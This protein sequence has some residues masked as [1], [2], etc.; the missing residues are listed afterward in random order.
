M[1]DDYA[2]GLPIPAEDA[3]RHAAYL[4]V[5]F[6]ATYAA[7]SAALAHVP[8]EALA[9]VRTVLDIGAGPGTASLAA[10][11][12]APAVTHV[13]HVDRS[14]PLLDTGSRLLTEVSGDR[15]VALTQVVAD[16]ASRQTWPAADLVMAAYALAELPTPARS[17]LVSSAWQATTSVLVLVEPGTPAGF[18]RIVEARAALIASGATVVAPCPHGGPCPLTRVARDD[19]RDWCHFAVRVPRSRRH[20]QA[21]AASRGYEDE[22]L[23]YLV[24][25]RAHDA[26]QTQA[27]VLRH[28]II[29]KGRI[30][31]TLCDVE[32]L[33]RTIVTK[34]DDA[35]RAA[36]KVEWGD[37]WRTAQTR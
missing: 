10:L 23:S 36:R 34:R 18:D 8:A 2:S 15:A 33:R 9:L 29:E 19:G 6:P 7:V 11:D 27:R 1:S 31:L 25:L 32:G 5:R 35:W 24:A 26:R 21:K 17:A 28:P 4:A 14:R 16:L 13:A 20:R 3:A 30:T 22:K 12:V 37:A